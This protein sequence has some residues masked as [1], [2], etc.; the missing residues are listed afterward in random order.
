MFCGEDEEYKVMVLHFVNLATPN[1]LHN[2]VGY[3]SLE[4]ELPSIDNYAYICLLLT[5]HQYYLS[6]SSPISMLLVGATKEATPNTTRP[7]PHHPISSLAATLLPAVHGVG[8]GAIPFLPLS[9]FSSPLFF[10]LFCSLS[11][12]LSLDP[13]PDLLSTASW[14]MVRVGMTDSGCLA[15]GQRLWGLWWWR[16]ASPHVAE[17]GWFVWGWQRHLLMLE[18]SLWME[19][20]GLWSCQPEGVCGSKVDNAWSAS[21]WMARR[22]LAWLEGWVLSIAD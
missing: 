7:P 8:G 5:F 19:R 14:L 10:L 12:S 21:H 4:V 20:G 11:L 13:D 3:D 9:S 2:I 17:V 16:Q 18:V 22:V 6:G 15:E 1:Y